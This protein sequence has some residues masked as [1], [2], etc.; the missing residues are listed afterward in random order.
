MPGTLPLGLCRA[1]F[2][3]AFRLPWYGRLDRRASRSHHQFECWDPPPRMALQYRSRLPPI[4]GVTMTIQPKWL[5]CPGEVSRPAMEEEKVSENFDQLIQR[6][7]QDS[8]HPADCGR[9]KR[10]QQ[11]GE[12]R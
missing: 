2:R 11:H 4:T 3:F 6:E 12:R 5:C 9:Q 8:R 1:D 7:G 10:D